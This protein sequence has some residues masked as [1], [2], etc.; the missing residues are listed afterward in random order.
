MLL[1]CKD[2][3]SIIVP[4][5]NVEKY[6]ERCIDSIINQTYKNLEII[7]IDDGSTDKC[8][9]ICENYKEKD[10]RIIV[11][12]KENGGLSTA[13]NRGLDISTGKYILFV[14]SDDYICDTMIEELLKLL[15]KYNADIAHCNFKIVDEFGNNMND[16]HKDL[17]DENLMNSYETIYSY[18]VDYRVKVMAWNKLYRRELFDYIRFKDGYVY[19]D[20][21]IFPEIIS[22][23]ELNITTNKKLYFYTYNNN[24]ITKTDFNES[25]LKSK[26]YLCDFLEK[27]YLENYEDLMYHVYM[28][29]CF[30][31]VG[32]I[33]EIKKSKTIENKKRE[34]DYMKE[35][36]AIS[37]SKM[38]KYHKSGKVPLRK[39]IYLYVYNIGIDLKNKISL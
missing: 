35:K 27:F 34:I 13:R 8:R 28:M 5:Y 22:K 14:D 11:D 7:L 21:I 37:Y 1:E 23:S 9:N 25:K 39:D 38:K 32:C 33:R 18:I 17:Y 10:S 20:E 30:I 2:K 29:I 31:C 24:S 36:Y 19:E 3:V 4:I 15:L 16:K 26:K 6:L 12:H